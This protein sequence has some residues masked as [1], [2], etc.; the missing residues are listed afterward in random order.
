MTIILFLIDTSASMNQRTFM[1]TSLMDVAKA[2]VETFMKVKRED[3]K[4]SVDTY[5]FLIVTFTISS[6][7]D[8][9]KLFVLFL[10]FR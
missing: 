2:A 3:A 8:T 6:D 10:L 1:G 5:R 9:Y 4:R 7:A